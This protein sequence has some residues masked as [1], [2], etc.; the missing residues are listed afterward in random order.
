MS[1]TVMARP[2]SC[3]TE[4]HRSSFATENRQSR[5]SL[6][7][8]S[9]R[10]YLVAQAG[11]GEGRL[12]THCCPF[13]RDKGWTAVDP[14]VWTGCRSQVRAWCR[15]SLICIRPVDRRVGRGLDGNTHAPLISLAERPRGAAIR[16][17]RFGARLSIR[18]MQ[19]LNRELG[20][21]PRLL[22]PRDLEVGIECSV[23]A[24]HAPGDAGKFVGQCHRE[25]I[26]MQ[27]L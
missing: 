13:P 17:A 8:G 1:D 16:V 6:R 20:S 5:D 21:R 15:K 27:P 24:Q 3:R 18:S 14:H 23:V 19:I 10:R 4:C 9:C 26:P 2:I 11:R 22:D 7:N 25:L 12:S